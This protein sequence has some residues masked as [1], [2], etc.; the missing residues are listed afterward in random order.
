MFGSFFSASEH[1]LGK[2]INFTSFLHGENPVSEDLEKIL[3]LASVSLHDFV[4]HTQFLHLSAS[5]P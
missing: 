3:A 1:G 5:Q 4:L 2:G